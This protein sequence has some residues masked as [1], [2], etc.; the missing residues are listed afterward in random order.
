M[1]KINN[2]QAK[3]LKWV[4]RASSKDQNRPNITGLNFNHEIAAADGYRIHVIDSIETIDLEG[5]HE[6]GNVAKVRK[7]QHVI[8]PEPITDE[9]P[10]YEGRFPAGDPQVKIALNPRFLAEVCQGLDKG[11]MLVIS[12][13][14]ENKPIVFEGE[15][16]EQP[17]TALIMPM[18]MHKENKS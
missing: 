10:D 15:L 8:F 1:Y 5:N 12:I 17:V 13:W 7:D 18:H 16:E 3:R 14:D 6:I 4:S 9:F 2:K 11:S